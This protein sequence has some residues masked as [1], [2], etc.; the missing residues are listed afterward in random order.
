M[1]SLLQPFCLFLLLS[2]FLSAQ[3]TAVSQL[4]AA[5]T[6][7]NDVLAQS[8]EQTLLSTQAPQST[9]LAAGVLLA[10]HDKLADS[11]A[12]FERCSQLY[13]ASFE[14][15]YNLALA[16]ISLADY[17]AALAALNS[18][19]PATE[20]QKIAVEY[21]TG[22]VFLSTNHLEEAQKAL[23]DA[24][25]HRPN[26][27]N[28]ALDLGLL[29]VR[30]AAYLPAIEVLQPSLVIHPQSEELSLE[31]AMAEVLAGR[32]GDGIDLCRKLQQQDPD[33][34]ISRLIA[35]FAYCTQKDYKACEKESSAGLASRH[36]H[37]YLYYL[38][39]TARWDSGA[40]H[41]A[42]ILDDVSKSIQQMPGCSVCL[43]LRS[44]IFEAAHQDASAIADLKR[45][46]ESNAQSASAW[47]R[48]AVLYRKTGQPV[49]ASEAL[50]QYRSIHNDEAAQEAESF[51]KQF[52]EDVPSKK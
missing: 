33:L 19:S 48:L 4:S 17:P 22:K 9:L 12:M 32:Y 1:I 41:S 45:A 25:A 29:Y 36:P 14:A 18:A 16:R 24:Y 7:D 20:E 51:R 52:L 31:L 30:S 44:R 21:L 28:Y 39:A 11:A 26:N 15:K 49:E 42:Q 50:Q 3:D 46:L 43:L 13:P 27:E 35:A 6:A 38:R 23:A 2:L 8:I 40:T 5:L 47:Y 34:S 37:P 10:E